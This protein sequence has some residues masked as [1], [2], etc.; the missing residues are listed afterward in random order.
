MVEETNKLDQSLYNLVYIDG[1]IYRLAMN[2]LQ[3]SRLLGI[4]EE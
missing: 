4:G 2:E 1:M 3:T